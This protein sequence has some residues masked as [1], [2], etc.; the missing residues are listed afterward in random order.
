MKPWQP[1]NNA[2]QK[3]TLVVLD[4]FR[5]ASD[6]PEQWMVCIYTYYSPTFALSGQGLGKAQSRSKGFG[7]L[8]E[9]H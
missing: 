7:G 4:S 1:V 6:L 5:K 2:L 8:S 9:T 3:Q